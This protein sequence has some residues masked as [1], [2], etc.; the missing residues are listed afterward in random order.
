MNV[1]ISKLNFAHFTKCPDIMRTWGGFDVSALMI[2]NIAKTYPQHNFFYIGLNDIN[3]LDEPLPNLIDIETPIKQLKSKC[4]GLEKYEVAIKYYTDNNLHFDVAIYWYCRFTNLI[5]YKDNYMTK[6][7]TYRKIRACEKNLCHILSIPKTFNI[8]TY[9]LIDDITEIDKLPYDMNMPNGVW[10][11]CNGNTTA[12]RYVSHDNPIREKFAIPLTYKPIEKLWLQGKKKVDWRNIEKPNKFIV[13]CNGPADQSLD[14]FFY[15]KKWVFDLFD[16]GVVYGKWTSPTKLTDTIKEYN[17]EDK[18]VWKGICEMEDLMFKTKY[19][20]V[21]PP[22]KKWPQFVTQKAYSMIYYGIIPF[23]CKNDYD[24]DNIYKEFPDFIKVETPE[25]LVEKINYLENNP[26]EYT[27]LLN[28][29]Y[30]LLDDR[31]FNNQLIKDIFDEIL[32]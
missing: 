14:K 8:P 17:Y 16:D 27:K 1:L 32:V 12:E 19:T 20:I 30:D 7:G 29:L 21:V 2:Y 10:S 11:Q 23:W 28:Q 15:V 4:K 25:E 26:E 5:N 22:S 13:T 24:K 3:E 9:Y 31:Y 18:F 6:K